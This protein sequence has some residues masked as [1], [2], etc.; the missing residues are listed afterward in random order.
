MG[1]GEKVKK[2]NTQTVL[3]WVNSVVYLA[4]FE[5]DKKQ[6]IYTTRIDAM[7]RIG[8]YNTF[9]DDLSTLL[10]MVIDVEPIKFK[11]GGKDF[12]IENVERTIL[13]FY[14]L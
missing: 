1:K 12:M 4:G 5:Y 11:M 6:G 14:R 9:Y 2:E 10:F 13:R 8:G 7:Q 3:N